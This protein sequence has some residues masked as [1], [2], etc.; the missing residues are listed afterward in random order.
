MLRVLPVACVVLLAGC[1]V[2]GAQFHPGVAAQVGDTT[3]TTRHVDQL[4]HDSCRGLEELNKAGSSQ[5]NA[6]TPLGTITHQVTN[7]LIGKVVAQ[8]LADD[9]DVSPSAD[10]K[11]NLNQTRQQLA[12]LSETDR[13]AIMEVIEAQAYTQD[14][15]VQVGEIELK[16]QGKDDTAT[17]D[18]YNEGQ[19]L[20]AKWVADHDVEINPKYGIDYGTDGPVD[21]ALSYDVRGAKTDGFVAQSSSDDVDALPGDLVCFD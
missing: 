3:V 13:D 2:A 19:K 9:Y 5:P 10:Y 21:T 15:L 20:A 7:A 12:K 1:G 8:Q 16:K 14:V 11:S 6:P 17:Q 18:Q 4:S